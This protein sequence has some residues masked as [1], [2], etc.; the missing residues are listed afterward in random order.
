MHWEEIIRWSSYSADLPLQGHQSS[1]EFLKDQDL[2][3]SIR[4][5]YYSYSGSVLGVGSVHKDLYCIVDTK[6]RYWPL[7]GSFATALWAD[8][9]RLAHL[10]GRLTHL[11]HLTEMLTHLTKILTHLTVRLTHLTERM[12]HL[13]ERLTRLTETDKSERDWHT[14]QRERLKPERTR[15]LYLTVTERP[16]IQ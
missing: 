14:L 2:A 7:K 11:T 12:A 3:V 9:E 13:T 16:P 8:S 15:D 10:T 1:R 6:P 4:S 5:D